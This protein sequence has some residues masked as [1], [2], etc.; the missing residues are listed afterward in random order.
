MNISKNLSI[1]I[2]D[3]SVNKLEMFRKMSTS[4]R[5]SSCL[6]IRGLERRTKIKVHIRPEI[7]PVAVA[8]RNTV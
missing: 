7:T 1:I 5:N 8:K 2:A 4:S 3:L 6:L